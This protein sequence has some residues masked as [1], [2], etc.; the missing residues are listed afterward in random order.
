MEV[1][2]LDVAKCQRTYW[3][4]KTP[5]EHQEFTSIIDGKGNKIEDS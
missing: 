2:Y 4:G 3:N 1:E 5:A